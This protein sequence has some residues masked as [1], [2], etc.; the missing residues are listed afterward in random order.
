MAKLITENVVLIPRGTNKV[1]DVWNH[2]KTEKLYEFSISNYVVGEIAYFKEQG[3]V[4]IPIYH[5]TW[6]IWELQ[7]EEAVKIKTISGAYNYSANGQSVVFAKNGDLFVTSG[8]DNSDGNKLRRY[9]YLEES[10]DWSNSYDTIVNDI[11]GY[12]YQSNSLVYLEDKNQ[13]WLFIGR[14]L[15]N[16]SHARAKQEELV[17]IFDLATEQL[18]DPIYIYDTPFSSGHT[19]YRYFY[20]YNLGTRPAQ[21]NHNIISYN[22]VTEKV[23]IIADYTGRH[24]TSVLE[25]DSK[26]FESK[27]FNTSKL[28]GERE[29]RYAQIFSSELSGKTFVVTNNGIVTINL[30]GSLESDLDYRTSQTLNASFDKMSD[31]FYSENDGVIMEYIQGVGFVSTD[32]NDPDNP[33]HQNIA[34]IFNQTVR[35]QLSVQAPKIIYPSMMSKTSTTPY[36]IIKM[37]KSPDGWTQGLQL[38]MDKDRVKIEDGG[39]DDEYIVKATS[40]TG[41]DYTDLE[42]KYSEDY[43]EATNSGTWTELGTGLPKKVGGVHGVNGVI[44]DSNK[45]TVYIKLTAP[46]LDIAKWYLEVATIVE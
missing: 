15:S 9:K 12:S 35:Q 22:S 46:K 3:F 11:G 32:I 21:K 17:K 34:H 33:V 6:E 27:G 14:N 2:A 38:M 18:L 41:D 19:S 36:I 25:I 40:F 37:G 7:N 16:V 44:C 39:I 4:A 26:N 13:I 24:G 23:Y 43:D 10:R 20:N 5:S 28:L 29:D 42:W 45:P 8:A 30:D 31:R 1:V